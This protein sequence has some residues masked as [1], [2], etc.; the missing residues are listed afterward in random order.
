MAGPY[1]RHPRTL[2]LS[3]LGRQES[4]EN[5]ASKIRSDALGLPVAVAGGLGPL[6]S[7]K[8]LRRRFGVGRGGLPARLGFSQRALGGRWQR[9]AIGNGGLVTHR[10]AS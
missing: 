7:P 5:R 8:L 10:L 6:R 9:L 1:T 2:G 3:R 4:P